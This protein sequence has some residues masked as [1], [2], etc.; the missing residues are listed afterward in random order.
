MSEWKRLEVHGLRTR[1][2][3]NLR[4]MIFACDSTFAWKRMVNF[5]AN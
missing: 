1:T 2:M 5:S 4:T 3:I